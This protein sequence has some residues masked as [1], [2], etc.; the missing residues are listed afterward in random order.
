MK[1]HL[2]TALAALATATLAPAAFADTDPSP[3]GW[4]VRPMAELA[5]TSGGDAL[6]HVTIVNEGTNAQMGSDTIKAGSKDLFALGAELRHGGSPV[7]LQA[8]IG[9]H[10]HTTTGINGDVSFSRMPIELLGMYAV[11]PSLRLGAGLHY[12]TRVYM[13]GKG[14]LEDPSLKQRYHNALGGVL[15]AEWLVTP[16]TGIEVRYVRVNYK[17]KSVDGQSVEGIPGIPTLD[18]RSMGVGLNAYF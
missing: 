18:G 16:S 15:K 7:A 8:T 11:L 2:L 17:L 4:E 5:F 1:R 3:A 10:W 13:N 9:Y 6:I 14:V 12:D